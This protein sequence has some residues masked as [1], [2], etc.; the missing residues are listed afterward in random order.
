MSMTQ[1][2]VALSKR[3]RLKIA[4][5]IHSL[6]LLSISEPVGISSAGGAIEFE[7]LDCKLW[8]IAAVIFGLRQ[9]R[10]SPL[11]NFLYTQTGPGISRRMGSQS[12]ML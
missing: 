11:C 2:P 8:Y 3:C 6:E 5:L 9:S 7:G 1:T 4:R 12:S 10:F